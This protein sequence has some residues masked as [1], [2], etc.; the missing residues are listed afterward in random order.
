MKSSLQGALL[1]QQCCSFIP[2]KEIAQSIPV[3]PQSPD[4]VR[5]QAIDFFHIVKFL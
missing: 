1:F 5:V 3:A 4:D 2:A